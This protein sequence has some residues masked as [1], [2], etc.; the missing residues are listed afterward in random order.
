MNCL[1]VIYAKRVCTEIY[2]MKT[3]FALKWH[4]AQLRIN[5]EKLKFNITVY[6]VTSVHKMVLNIISTKL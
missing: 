3:I 1:L 2:V 4:Y 6:L 5:G